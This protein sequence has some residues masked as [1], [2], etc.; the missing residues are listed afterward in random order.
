METIN[1]R[2]ARKSDAPFISKAIMMAV[3]DEITQDF[4]GSADRVALVDKLFTTLAERDDSQYSYLNTIV[5]EADGQVAGV[6]ICY[7][8]AELY[9]RREAFLEEAKAILGEDLRDKMQDET[10]PD[11]IYLDTLAV[12][13]PYRHK[14]IASRLIEA[15][16]QKAAGL[17]KPL[18][19]LVDKENDR[20]AALYAKSGFK[21]VGERPFAGVMMNH[22]RLF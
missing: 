11:E 1:L 4:A 6:V 12:F 10:S 15:A 20:A 17:N 21:K 5:A 16:R 14:G 8:G 18:A 19:L 13:E 7:D 9:P 22:M 3:G 2:P